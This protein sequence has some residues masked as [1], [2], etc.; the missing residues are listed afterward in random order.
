MLHVRLTFHLCTVQLYHWLIE[1]WAWHYW[2]WYIPNP[3][4]SQ[5]IPNESNCHPSKY[6]HRLFFFFCLVEAPRWICQGQASIVW[7]QPQRFPTLI[8]LDFSPNLLINFQSLVFV[9]G[10]DQTE[11]VSWPECQVTHID[12]S[13]HCTSHPMHCI[14]WNFGGV[15]HCS[16]SAAVWFIN[17]RQNVDVHS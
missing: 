3:G 5:K 16:A 7:Q 11:I 4:N 14:A 6:Q 12:E 9:H 10:L 1:H 8:N 15:K 2:T 13:A 17:S